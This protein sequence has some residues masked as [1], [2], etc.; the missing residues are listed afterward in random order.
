MPTAREQ[1]AADAINMKLDMRGESHIILIPKNV[2]YE[3]I[4]KYL[5]GEE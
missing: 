3:D 5:L 2:Q 1:A 4:I